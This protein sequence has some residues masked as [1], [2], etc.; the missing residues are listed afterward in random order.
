M[1][2]W[3]YSFDLF[4]WPNKMPSI[5]DAPWE[6]I[7]FWRAVEIVGMTGTADLV[8]PYW[9]FISQFFTLGDS[10]LSDLEL[11]YISTLIVLGIC[12]G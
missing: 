5:N 12:D 4:I 7:D 2:A 11:I 8:K 1:L 10:D 6:N 9:F 3:W